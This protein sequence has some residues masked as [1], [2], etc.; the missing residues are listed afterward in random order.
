MLT[1]HP[2]G[3]PN[4]GAFGQLEIVEP[5]QK[6]ATVIFEQI[7]KSAAKFEQK[8][9]DRSAELAWFAK[10]HAIK[11]SDIDK[12]NKDAER[13]FEINLR[14]YNVLKEG[15]AKIPSVPSP[16]LITMQMSGGARTLHIGRRYYDR[17]TCLPGQE[18]PAFVSVSEEAEPTAQPLGIAVAAAVPLAPLIITW[19]GRILATIAGGLMLIFT[20]IALRDLLNASSQIQQDYNEFAKDMGQEILSEVQKCVAHAEASA[21]ARGVAFD[22]LTARTICDKSVRESFPEVKRP[23]TRGI[24]MTLVY[25]GLGIGAVFA[26]LAIYRTVKDGG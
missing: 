6:M 9:Y 17:V 8:M 12:Y 2:I 19:G 24:L 26:G 4:S 3:Q 1:I 15:G 18:Y 22:Y 20:L 16:R 25:A 23:E 21:L 14:M 7:A 11:C 5:L 10:R 13:L